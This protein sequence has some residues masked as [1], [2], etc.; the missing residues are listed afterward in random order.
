MSDDNISSLAHF[1]RI[2]NQSLVKP[3]PSYATFIG[4]GWVGAKP[5]FDPVTFFG[6]LGWGFV[7]I[8]DQRSATVGL[9]E[10][11]GKVKLSTDY[12]Q[13]ETWVDA[14]TRRL[15]ILEDKSSI[16]LNFDHFLDF[17]NNKEKIPDSWKEAYVVTFD[18]DILEKSGLCYSLGL[19]WADYDRQWHWSTR[20]F[21]QKSD[22]SC[23]A[24]VVES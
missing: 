7:G 15:R 5:V 24:A 1:Q 22:A 19:H 18:G 11:Y 17:W 10:D 20:L 6:K 23:P 13:G 2:M 12:L 8:R 16:S 9:I 4:S 3:A 14:K 21:N